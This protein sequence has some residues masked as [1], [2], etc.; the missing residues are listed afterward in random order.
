MNSFWE[1]VRTICLV[2][3]LIGAGEFLF[4]VGYLI[5]CILEEVPHER[6]YSGE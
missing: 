6:Y 1:T 5:K 4:V 2:L 3:A